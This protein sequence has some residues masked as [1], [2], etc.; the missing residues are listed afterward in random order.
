MSDKYKKLLIPI[1]KSVV[2]TIDEYDNI[3]KKA[4]DDQSESEPAPEYLPSSGP[5]SYDLEDGQKAS[6]D[7]D[8]D[9][10]CNCGNL[11][12]KLIS[13]SAGVKWADP[14]LLI[15]E[16]FQDSVKICDFNVGFNFCPPPYCYTIPEECTPAY[17]TCTPGYKEC[18][19]S[20]KVCEK[21]FGVKIC[22]PYPKVC[23]DYPETCVDTPEECTPA[24]TVCDPPL[25]CLIEQVKLN[26]TVDYDLNKFQLYNYNS[27]I[28]VD[29]DNTTTDAGNQ[30]IY[31]FFEKLDFNFTVNVSCV[32]TEIF[33]VNNGNI[34]DR[35]KTFNINL[36]NLT[37]M[38][39]AV[40]IINDLGYASLEF[41]C[42]G[43]L[44]LTN[45]NILNLNEDGFHLTIGK[46]YLGICISYKEEGVPSI[47]AR[48]QFNI[49]F[50]YDLNSNLDDNYFPIGS[51]TKFTQT[52]TI[53]IP[54]G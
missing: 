2:K 44:E 50:E 35:T 22:T 18:T 41:D 8:L 24:Y 46:V 45:K 43:C 42:G 10:D 12:K 23:T 11:I 36:K 16:R 27:T 20:Y 1:L 6:D 9:I 13:Y 14:V 54:I 48:L 30:A 5:D 51:K 17:K 3:S 7:L 39:E 15:D 25:P 4:R 47:T 37:L 32:D 29:S 31:I 40:E 19:P 34:I 26:V 28:I 33:W 49:D 53:P 21:S 38:C 52:T